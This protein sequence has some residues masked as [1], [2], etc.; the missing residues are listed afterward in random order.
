MSPTTVVVQPDSVSLAKNAQATVLAVA[1]NA[2]GSPLPGYLTI[3]SSADTTIA[4]VSAA[5]TITGVSAGTTTVTA[6][7]GQAIGTVG[8]RVLATTTSVASVKV[9][10]DSVTVAAGTTTPFAATARDSAG[11]TLAGRVITWTSANTAVAT[12]SSTGLVSAVG[13]GTAN[14]NA[15]SEG[16]SGLGK[17]TVTA[18]APP[19]PPP[20]PSGDPLLPTV[21][22][23]TTY[24]APTGK[25]IA[26]AAGGDL[27]AAINAA[28]PGDVITAAAGATFVGPF[29][30]PNKS[31]TGWVTIR[32]DAPAANLPAEGVR[33]GPKYAT[34]MPKLVTN[35]SW[36]ALQTAAGAHHYR[37]I[38]LEI[39]AGSSATMNYG[40]LLLGDGSSAQ[41]AVALVPNNLILDRVYIH[42]HPTLNTSRCVGLNSAST[43]VIDS[44][45]SE[46]HALGFDSQAIGGW[47]GPGPYKIVNNY[48][49]GA[50]E[51]V[52]FG[53]ADPAIANQT[54]SD[55]E[56][57][58]NHFTRPVSWKGVWT[59]KNLF[60][61]KHAQRVLVEGNL[62]EN[63]W[64]DAQDG[65]A[66]VWKSVNQNGTAPWSVT[67]DVTFRLNRLRN[68]GGGVNLAAH[69]EP[70]TVVPAN[71]IK[72]TDNVFEMLN[73]GTFTGN[74]RVYQMLGELDAL[75]ITHNTTFASAA[76]TMFAT[77]P[78]ATNFIF[79]DN[80]ST[81]G[82]YGVFGSGQGEGIRPLD[83]Y[84]APG[85]VFLRNVIIS[86]PPSLYP[87]G[88]FY[89]ATVA[90]VG[91]VDQ[92]SGNYRLLST[93]AYAKQATD[94]RDPGADIDAVDRA[95]VG[96]VVP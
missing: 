53:G 35:G 78:Q 69:P 50:G 4:R 43:A 11:G 9:S 73:V 17:V 10:P 75:T 89:P 85:Y 59:V 86:A 21:Y 31:G 60:E 16:K 67:R 40:I 90:D 15:T 51:I 87:T 41:N 88:S 79:R 62:F 20:T 24:I 37:L 1:Y 29:T 33:S 27:Q 48:L 76:V 2:L 80:I 66:F 72:I 26:V 23:N 82:D 5:G 95:L 55:I 19:T 84:A 49:E 7:M 8:V 81:R 42:G 6:T 68:A 14:I 36:P 92:A 13:A 46:C 83:Y 56:I 30:L 18:V 34:A 71:H 12:V 94:G 28:L 77:L 57:R 38:G 39:T 22:L 93:S 52:M 64:A 25:T 58:H 65:F 32:S 91:F 96:V 47:N 61:L 54:P 74:G 70:P 3:W 63:H 44:Y 45:L